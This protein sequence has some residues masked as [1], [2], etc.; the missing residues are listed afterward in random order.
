MEPTRTT[1]LPIFSDRVGR[2]LALAALAVGLL[3]FCGAGCRSGD[4]NAA[5]YRFPDQGGTAAV[6]APAAPAPAPAPAPGTATPAPAPVAPIPAALASSTLHVGDLV[7][8]SFSDV[9]HP[10]L[11]EV[12]SRIPED[13][14]LT[15]HHNVRVKAAGR[16]I[17]DLERD[18]RSAFVPR[19]YRNL[20][21]IV[22]AE[23]RFFYVGGE[24]K[25]NNRYQLQ[26]EMT[27]LRAIDSA[28]G[29]TEFADRNRIELRRQDGT[30]VMLSEKKIKKGQAVD[31]PVQANDHITVKKRWF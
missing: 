4:P 28:G 11:Q 31:L 9:P 20:T 29:F 30:V 18:I 23:D 13:G 25:V 5:S 14:M 7:T 27:V 26:S 10:G 22:R 1:V 8:V 16:T 15:L 21:A 19:L 6:P 24:V 17:P 2:I 12:R 3:A